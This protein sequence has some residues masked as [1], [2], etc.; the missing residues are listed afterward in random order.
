M[1]RCPDECIQVVGTC[2]DCGGDLI[3]DSSCDLDR[4]EVHCD[5]CCYGEYDA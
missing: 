4:H 5:K 1:N 2:P 3:V